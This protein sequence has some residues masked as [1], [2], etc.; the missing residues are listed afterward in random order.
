MN[1]YSGI[2]RMGIAVAVALFN[3]IN[4]CMVGPNYKPPPAP[5]AE[6]YRDPGS[7]QI[8]RDPADLAKWWTVFGD[9]TLN[10][11]VQSAYER[12]PN[13]QSAAVRVLEAQARRGIAVGLLFPQQQNAFG[14][15]TYNH[16]SENQ[17][18]SK[19]LNRTFENWQ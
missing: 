5:V 10:S 7:E 14:E 12:N 1:R 19:G 17:V 6:A 2:R 15:Y 18:N 8:K 16:L 4:G 13:L 9:P 11:L 3:F